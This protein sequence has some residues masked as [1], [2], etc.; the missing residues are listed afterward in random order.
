[1]TALEQQVWA[2]AFAAAFEADRI[3]YYRYGDGTKTVD[4]IAGFSCAE[5]A[6]VAVQK[7]REALTGPDREYLIPVREGDVK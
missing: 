7:L 3:L 5:I 4:D 6:D 1:M 2:A